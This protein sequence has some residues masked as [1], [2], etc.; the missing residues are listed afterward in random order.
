MAYPMPLHTPSENP[1][2]HVTTTQ[3]HNDSPIFHRRTLLRGFVAGI[4]SLGLTGSVNASDTPKKTDGPAEGTEAY[5]KLSE[6]AQL[7]FAEKLKS[8]RE[9]ACVLNEM[10][11]TIQEFARFAGVKVEVCKCMDGR[12]H[13]NDHKGLPPTFAVNRRSQGNVIDVSRSNKDLWDGIG[14]AL[15]EAK[16]QGV[17]LL[18]IGSAH[19]A[20][21]GSGC[22]AH[23][24][25][26]DTRPADGD[27]RALNA[28]KEQ[29]LQFR[30]A[31]GKNDNVQILS[32]MTNTDTGAMAFY[33]R[34]EVFSAEA[35]MT[36]A[37]LRDA[38]DVYEGEFMAQKIEEDWAHLSIKGK[39]P[40]QLLVGS[41][42]P[43]FTDLRTKIAFEAYLM[44]R[45]AEAKPN[46]GDNIVRPDILEQMQSK[47]GTVHEK[48]KPFLTY[49]FSMNLAHASHRRNG[50]T[51][52]VKKK[53]TEG[54]AA[55]VEH[56]ERVLGYGM[57]FDLDKPNS[58]ILVKPGGGN[59]AQSVAIGHKVLNH[60]L[61]AMHLAEKLPPLV[62]INIE[63]PSPIQNW[64]EYKVVL[65]RILTKVG[66]V[67]KEF[68]TNVRILTSY[69]YHQSVP[70]DEKGV[71]RRK[72]YFPLNA[73][74]EN[75][76][77]VVTNDQDVGASMQSQ[78]TFSA[79]E[80]R[81]RE[82]QYT[83]SGLAVPAPKS[84]AKKP[85]TP[86]TEA[87]K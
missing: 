26:W 60:N 30:S 33:D 81:K 50:N 83:N 3:L 23:K 11:P 27:S 14:A 38:R 47:L 1:E 78:R 87:K 28:V 4:V 42:A 70:T 18:I 9:G 39:T 25:E 69:S 59:D 75:K 64:E 34:D 84:G 48:L 19:R 72:Q 37:K 24:K 55:R 62:H 52:L 56:G 6:A 44:R 58:I 20:E 49:M 29:T 10:L 43:V 45:V 68:G 63:L 71:A 41:T 79:A 76:T 40:A 15:I 7:F 32:A 54:L 12:L 8:N 5:E 31:F 35:V 67:N 61:E 46:P 53:D 65:A 36:K 74:P 2:Q 66:I 17:P 16:S 13:G 82:S 22:A 86:K 80:L 51:E 77:I 85:E 57:G 21:L 73:D